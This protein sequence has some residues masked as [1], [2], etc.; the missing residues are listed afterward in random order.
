[1]RGSNAANGSSPVG[2]A[3]NFT[4][5]ADFT[6]PARDIVHAPVSKRPIGCAAIAGLQPSHRHRKALPP[7]QPSHAPNSPLKT[8]TDFRRKMTILD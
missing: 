2:A 7:T 8:L 1:V 4:M 3:I 5:L 6:M